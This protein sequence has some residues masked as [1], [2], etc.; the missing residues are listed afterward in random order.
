MPN[1]TIPPS[2][3]YFSLNIT[4][5]KLK[6]LIRVKRGALTRSLKSLEQYIANEFDENILLKS[7][8]NAVGAKKI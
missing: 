2:I 8:D 7:Y 6:A 4:S 5:E 1:S 3:Q